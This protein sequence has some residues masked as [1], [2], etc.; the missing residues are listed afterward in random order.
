MANQ[1]IDVI[2]QTLQECNK[3]VNP[4][5]IIPYQVYTDL[6]WGGLIGTYGNQLKKKV[7]PW[8]NKK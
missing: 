2:A 3:D 6:A 7:R 5:N 1:Y 4:N 8:Q